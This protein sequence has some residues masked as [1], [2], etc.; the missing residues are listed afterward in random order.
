MYFLKRKPLTLAKFQKG[1]R[2]YAR[3]EALLESAEEAYGDRHLIAR[4]MEGAKI[5]L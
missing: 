3:H 4:Q 1:N 2:I 5:G